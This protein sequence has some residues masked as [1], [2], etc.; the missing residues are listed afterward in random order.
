MRTWQGARL[1]AAPCAL[2]LALLL[3]AQ[4]ACAQPA[5]PP[6]A[7]PETRARIVVTFVNAIESAPRPAGTTGPHYGGA[8]Y[9]VG[10]S[11]HAMARRVANQYSLKEVASWPIKVL[12]VHCVVYE[13]PDARTVSDVL[14][15]LSKDPDIS[16]A[17]PLQEFH[18]LS[19]PVEGETPPY[20]DPLYDLQTNLSTLGIEHAHARTRGAG[21][22]VGLIDTGVDAR[23]PDLQGRIVSTLSFVPTQAAS[24]RSYRHGTAMAGLIAAVANNHIG[25]VGIAPL[26]QLEV[27]EACWQLRPD[28]DDAAC[29][30]FSLAKAIAAAIDA[31]VPLVNLSISG[32]EDPLLTKLIRAGIGSG[33]TFVG[34]AAQPGDGFPSHIPGLLIAGSTE[35]GSWPA[36]LTAPANHV[37]TLRPDGAYDFES[38]TS[39]AAAEVTGA[40]ALLI[41]A[42]HQRLST[43]KIGSLLTRTPEP[44]GAAVATL[45]VPALNINDALA[46]LDLE[47]HRVGVSYGR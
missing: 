30:T 26:A 25:I 36:T 29:S 38:G 18:T 16:I 31:K 14:A 4:L 43:Q 39:V 34:A 44:P 47:Q 21:V 9:L 11:A 17:Q 7:S 32:P 19:G 5:S 22:R 24:P 3:T 46:A 2:C 10:Q 40:V 33:V 35:H 27:F 6:A 45:D 28:A 41:S 8:A 42:S 15:Q 20:N 37:F 13:I 1:R 12:S 23:H